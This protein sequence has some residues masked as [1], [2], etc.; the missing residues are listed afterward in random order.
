[1]KIKN[2]LIVWGLFLLAFYFSVPAQGVFAAPVSL[3]ISPPLLEAVVQ[4]GRSIT[5]AYQVTN[6]GQIDLYLQ[7]KV[8]PFVPAGERGQ[9][10]L[11][12]LSGGGKNFLFSLQN[13]DV[14]MGET[15]FLP[16]GG[17]R[18]LVLQ[19][20]V[21]EEASN[22]DGYFTFLLAQS[23]QGEFAGEGGTGAGA[24]VKVGSNILLTVSSDG[25][26][27]LK[28]QLVRFTAQPKWG[29]I[30][31]PVQFL[32]M[33][34]NTGPS[35]FKT[36]G[37]IEVFDMLGRK[38]KTLQLQPDNV[39]AGWRREIDCLRGCF[40]SSLLPGRYRAVVKL[41]PG[42]LLDGENLPGYSRPV[43]TQE[44]YFWLLPIKL[45]LAL[46]VMGL[47]IIVGRRRRSG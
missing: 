37:E 9:V 44:V 10:R 38:R 18:Q 47:I 11:E 12:P 14:K 42:G 16:S 21:A 35:F 36:E 45:A 20:K 3:S 31:S 40:F 23:D 15:F 1:M 41:S 7:T 34:G 13:S 22:G 39:L 33:A 5:Q 6:N 24:L 43:Y 26:L 25:N 32:L 46:A 29:D 19:I 30:F 8:V 27:G 2:K 17:S 4:P 28:G